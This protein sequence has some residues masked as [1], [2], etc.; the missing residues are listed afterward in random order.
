MYAKVQFFFDFE[1]YHHYFFHAIMSQSEKIVILLWL[2]YDMH[3][4]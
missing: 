3:A 1:I 2:K 4:N